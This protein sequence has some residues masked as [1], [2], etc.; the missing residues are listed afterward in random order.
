LKP[1]EKEG[2][3]RQKIGKRNKWIVIVRE[4]CAK[5]EVEINK[6]RKKVK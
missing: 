4:K 1:R 3:T 2:R 6:S 5:W